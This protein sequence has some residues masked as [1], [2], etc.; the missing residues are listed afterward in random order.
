MKE[1][2][3]SVFELPCLQ[4]L[5]LDVSGDLGLPNTIYKL[6]RLRH[7]DLAI[8]HNV[9]GGGKLKFEGL[10]EL[11]TINWFDT[12]LDDTTDLL[13]LPK[14]Q[15]LNA[16]IR[17]EESLIMIVDFILNHQDQFRETKLFINRSMTLENDGST[18]F[19]KMLRIVS[20]S[21]LR[22]YC[23]VGKL[24]AYETELWQSMVYLILEGCYIDEDPMEI[25]ENLPM[26]RKLELWDN[27]YVGEQMVCRAS[28]FPKLT[29]LVVSTLGNLTEWRVEK[30]AMRSLS[31]L[32]IDGCDKLEMI[33]EGLK[34]ISTL[35]IL[36]IGSMPEEFKNRARVVD[37]RE[38]EDY[39]KIKHIPSIQISQY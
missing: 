6:R 10:N 25:L 28:G 32:Y 4:S 22:I 17:D 3:P 38:G 12:S 24:P 29:N 23:R 9:I 11:E 39:H 15:R 21:D 7:L 19:M 2:P 33:P 13:K 31:N 16:T 5:N 30:G 14:L 20:L 1:L 8:F 35:K 18:L 37:D 34:F 26:L 36:R 27:A